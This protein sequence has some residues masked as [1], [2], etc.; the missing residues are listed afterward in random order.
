MILQAYVYTFYCHPLILSSWKKLACVSHLMGSALPV[1]SGRIPVTGR[2][3]FAALY[4]GDVIRGLLHADK[5]TRTATPPDMAHAVSASHQN[6][7][8]FCVAL[9]LYRCGL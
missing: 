3:G 2:E 5:T 8:R 6:I 7:R 9:S 4:A 1:Y